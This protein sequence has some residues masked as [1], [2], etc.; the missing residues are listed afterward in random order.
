MNVIV[1][2]LGSMGR[3]RIR[4]LHSYDPTI[5]IVGVDTQK[6]RRNQAEK[7][8]KIE[9]AACIE[10]I[11]NKMDIDA[12]FIS[13]SPLSHAF[14]IEQC[15]KRNFHVFTELN[16]VDTGYE[17][18][19]QTARDKNKVLFLSSTFLYRKEI[20]YIKTSVDNCGCP[21]SYVY[22]AGQYL[23]D[24][25]PWENYKNFFVGNKATN[26]CREFMAIEFPWIIDTFGKIKKFHAVKDRV[27]SLDIDYPDSY[28]ITFEHETGHRGLIS[29]D[30]VS[31]KA[32]RNFELSGEN[33]YLTW[34]GTPDGLSKYDY[35]KKI[36]EPIQLYD[37]VN[38]RA[39]YSASIIEDAYYSEICNFMNVIKR[40]E[41]AKYSFE[42]DKYVL[43]LIDKIEGGDK[44]DK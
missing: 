16:L 30:V 14:L 28:W 37:K 10:D 23:P 4:L 5:T 21:L 33:L 19:I 20:E 41:N 15:L 34:D 35:S 6:E 2:G 17:K 42:K 36:D 39:D 9:T 40:K 43:S 38:K 31:R 22:H 1:I 32:I 44:D 27:S 12:S 24:W 7:E 26:G 29:I 13:T 25:H 3:R 8:L 11:D 18:N